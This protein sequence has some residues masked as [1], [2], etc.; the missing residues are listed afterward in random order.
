MTSV[1]SQTQKAGKYEVKQNVLLFNKSNFAEIVDL[2]ESG[3]TC[4]ALTDFSVEENLYMDIELLNCD[5]GM[6]VAG[7]SCKLV[8]K[9][10]DPQAALSPFGRTCTLEFPSLSQKKKEELGRFIK[11]SCFDH[12]SVNESLH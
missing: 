5:V 9:E 3:A 2:H 7:I 1:K 12:H 4:R 6:H 8:F 10:N 11:K